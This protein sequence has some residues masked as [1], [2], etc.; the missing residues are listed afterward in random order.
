MKPSR[1]LIG[2]LIKTIVGTIEFVAVIIMAV[3]VFAS[4]GNSVWGYWGSIAASLLPFSPFIVYVIASTAFNISNMNMVI[5]KI[6]T[7]ESMKK[8]YKKS[9]KYFI[10]GVITSSL[11]G[12]LLLP[13]FFLENVFLVEAYRREL[14]AI[15]NT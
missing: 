9:K 10:W 3:I 11:Y 15:N 6:H 5:K 7:R 4:D 13:I 1:L 14:K 12:F 8:Y 2:T